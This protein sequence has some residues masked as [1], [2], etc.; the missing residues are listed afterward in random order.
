MTSPLAA[1]SE[2]GTSDDEGS[3][4]RED[5]EKTLV[6]GI[7]DLVAKEVVDII[8]LNTV[9]VCRVRADG[10]NS[11]I[12]SALDMVDDVWRVVDVARTGRGL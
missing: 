3:L 1:T 11:K 10:V 2:C 12:S 7:Y 8:L 6:G 5:F 4:A 9:L